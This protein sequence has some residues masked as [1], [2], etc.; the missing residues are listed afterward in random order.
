MRTFMKDAQQFMKCVLQYICDGC[1]ALNVETLM[2][3]LA[4]MTERG[5]TGLNGSVLHM[6]FLLLQHNH[7]SISPLLINAQVI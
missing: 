2:C 7:H 6:L 4:E 5:I 1:I 3:L